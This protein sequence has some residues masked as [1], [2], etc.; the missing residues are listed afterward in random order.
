MEIESL[1]F[2]HY[3][4]TPKIAPNRLST[5]SKRSGALVKVKFKGFSRN[6]FAD[7]FPWPELGDEPLDLQVKSLIQ[8]TPLRLAAASLTWA[9]YEAKAASLGKKLTQEVSYPCHKTLLDRNQQIEPCFQIAKLKISAETLQEW[10]TI[11]ALRERY[12]KLKWRFDF[13]GL[14]KTKSEARTFYN[15]ISNAMLEAID[16]LEDPYCPELMEDPEALKIFEDL[17]VAVDRHPT[18]KALAVNEIWVIKPVYFSPEYLFTELRNFRGKVVITSNMDHALGQLTALHAAREIS[19]ILGARL[20]PGGLL[21]QD[22][23]ETYP[24]MNWVQHKQ[25]QLVSTKN[26]PGWGPADE[27]SKLLWTPA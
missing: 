10:E 3:Q 20:L 19:K 4:L 9:F 11:E 13:N 22:N 14:F 8:G 12:P 24:Q 27:L 6:G 7:L 17:A 21:T 26:D 16:F 23:F 15:K 1:S 25:N 2:H 18:P 5:V